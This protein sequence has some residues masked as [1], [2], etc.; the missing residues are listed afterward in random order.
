MD[1]NILGS[2]KARIEGSYAAPPPFVIPSNKTR[3]NNQFNQFHKQPATRKDFEP[4]PITQTDQINRKDNSRIVKNEANGTRTVF[5]RAFS[6]SH[7]SSSDETVCDSHGTEN[8]SLSSRGNA[9]RVNVDIRGSAV[10]TLSHYKGK[11]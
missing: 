7:S 2:I 10:P 5:K 11:C 1:R 9:G 8:E 6:R 4:Q 3:Y